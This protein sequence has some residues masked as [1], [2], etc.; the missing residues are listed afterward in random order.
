VGIVPGATA[1]NVV[2][3]DHFSFFGGGE[4]VALALQ[5]TLRADLLTGFIHG[6][7][8]RELL[9]ER[10]AGIRTVA[11]P[12]PVPLLRVSYLAAAFRHLDLRGYRAG[13]FA[14]MAAPF[15]LLGRPPPL[16]VI[17]C[18]TPPRYIYDQREHFQERIPRALRPLGDLLLRDIERGYR[19]A[20]QRADLVVANSR[21][22]QQ[23]LRDF[24][25]TAS[26]VIYP[27]V[28]TRS[29][30][31]LS[32]GEYYL[33]TAR[34]DGLK[35]VD[36][37]I[38]AFSQMPDKRLIVVSG[39]REERR[40]RERAS[41]AANIAFTGWV[42]DARLREL[43]GRCIATIYVPTDEDFGISPVESM[44]AGKPVIG[45]REG[46]LR[47]TVL[48]E[49]TGWLLDPRLEIGDLIAAV[50]ACTAERARP[51]RAACERQAQL[52]SDEVFQER[53]LATLGRL[54]A[55]KG[56]TGRSA[57]LEE[58]LPAGLLPRRAPLEATAGSV[59][60]QRRPPARDLH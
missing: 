16:S 55:E 28:P 36:R 4:R 34:L 5:T 48:H 31:W 51:M 39:G 57:D 11:T 49:R 2:L 30:R 50:R 21:N 38:D 7:H 29:L 15:A 27:P 41:N 54:A 59:P 25:G 24:L 10:L 9:A 60:S 17:Y 13:V 46:G 6:E 32:P 19:Q 37:I 35:R 23:R 44:A 3:H 20:L 1:R 8:T 52:F 26:E 22:I 58:A 40:L 18:H 45:V 42:S 14:G 53:L 33:S 12:M 56:L 43:I 47:E